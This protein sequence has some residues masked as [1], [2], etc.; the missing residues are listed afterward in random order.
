M[1]SKVVRQAAGFSL[2]TQKYI[3]LDKAVHHPVEA[4]RPPLLSRDQEKASNVAMEADAMEA[5]AMQHKV[6]TNMASCRSH[7]EPVTRGLP[8]GFLGYF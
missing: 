2:H 3:R 6:R 4:G 5:E 7:S 8:F 1:G